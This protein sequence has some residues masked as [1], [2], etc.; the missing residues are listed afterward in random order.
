MLIKK[1]HMNGLIVRGSSLS[2]AE[3]VLKKYDNTG[4]YITALSG[5]DLFIKENGI[6]RD[7]TQKEWEL[8]H[9]TGD[10]KC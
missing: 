6:V 1:K 9:T 7:S 2:I 3:K 10:I 5:Q 4:V 8:Y